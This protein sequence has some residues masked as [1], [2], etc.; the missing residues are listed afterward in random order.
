MGAQNGA[1]YGVFF[2]DGR[3]CYAHRFSYEFHT[4]RKLGTLLACHRCDNPSCV[5]PGHLFAGTQADN[6]GDMSRKL[7]KRAADAIC[8]RSG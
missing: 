8:R 2:A 4:G 6:M 7:W 5:R 1:G 3:Q